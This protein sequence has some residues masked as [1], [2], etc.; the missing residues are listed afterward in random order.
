MDPH[1]VYLKYLATYGLFG[2][3][4]F[5]LLLSFVLGSVKQIRYIKKRVN[6]A[7]FITIYC[8]CI[9][10]FILVGVGTSITRRPYLTIMLYMCAGL[11]VKY[12]S[13]I[14]TENTGK[15]RMLNVT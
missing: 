9:S 2:F 8:Y 4:P 13:L 14:K 11:L 6:K 12:I 5:I 3:T 1:N 15:D 7:I 10:Q